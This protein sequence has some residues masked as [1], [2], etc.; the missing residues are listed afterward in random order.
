MV[1]EKKVNAQQSAFIDGLLLKMTQRE[2]LIR[3][4]PDNKE[5]KPNQDIRACK[6]FAMPHVREEYNRRAKK[7]VDEVDKM[8]IITREEMI[9]KAVSMLETME[10]KKP[11]LM[12]VY[13]NGEY[14]TKEAYKTDAKNF[15]VLWGRL[16]TC[17]NFDIKVEDTNA[18]RDINITISKAE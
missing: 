4:Y 3:A 13:E 17:M 10:G 18:E 7:I 2:A 16:V 12:A 8:H 5:S 1:K 9:R 6:L 14:V 15:S 11:H